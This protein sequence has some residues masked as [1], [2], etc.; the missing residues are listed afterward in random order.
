MKQLKTYEQFLYED[1]SIDTKHD[2]I[3]LGRNDISLPLYDLNKLIHKTLGS[4]LKDWMANTNSRMVNF[5]AKLSKN[6]KFFKK[7]AKQ[8]DAEIHSGPNNLIFIIDFENEI[9]L[10][11]KDAT[12]HWTQI[13]K[14]AQLKSPQKLKITDLRQN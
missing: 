11:S 7:I 13:L 5:F 1:Y 2:F 8:G 10:I 3:D 4:Q 6:K 14:T 12:K 9:I